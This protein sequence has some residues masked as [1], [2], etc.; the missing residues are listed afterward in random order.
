MFSVNMTGDWFQVKL[1]VISNGV[2][3][4]IL[5]RQTV[6]CK[7]VADHLLAF[8]TGLCN[9]NLCFMFYSFFLHH[10]IHCCFKLF[11]HFH[12]F[13]SSCFQGISVCSHCCHTVYSTKMSLILKKLFLTRRVVKN[14]LEKVT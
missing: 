7:N 10:N 2:C 1:S 14:Y 12:R 4:T 11:S 6:V 5:Y 8:L 3:T 13:W 9:S